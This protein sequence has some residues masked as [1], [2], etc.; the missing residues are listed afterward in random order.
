MNNCNLPNNEQYHGKWLSKCV[1]VSSNIDILVL[2]KFTGFDIIDKK[3]K[4]F[5]IYKKDRSESTIIHAI[6]HPEQI[7]SIEALKLYKRIYIDIDPETYFR[8]VICIGLLKE[9]VEYIKFLIGEELFNTLIN[10]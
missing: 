8:T 4:Y 7:G 9:D 3:I 6:L 1:N 5:G 2:N 10:N